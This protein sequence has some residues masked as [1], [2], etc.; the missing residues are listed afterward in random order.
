MKTRTKGWKDDCT[1]ARHEP[2]RGDRVRARTAYMRVVVD[3]DDDDAH[4]ARRARRRA[5]SR[6]SMTRG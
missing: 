3:G 2:R 4:N 5:A 1:I 6:A